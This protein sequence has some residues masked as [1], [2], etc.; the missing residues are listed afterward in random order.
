VPASNWKRFNQAIVS[1]IFLSNL[2]FNFPYF[3]NKQ[4]MPDLSGSIPPVGRRYRR[5]S[6]TFCCFAKSE[7]ADGSPAALRAAD[8]ADHQLD[9]EAFPIFFSHE[10]CSFPARL[11]PEVLHRLRAKFRDLE[12]HLSNAAVHRKWL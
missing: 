7:T 4:P 1:S 12:P 8:E 2:S 6:T 11:A 9:L 10:P 3:L 5:A